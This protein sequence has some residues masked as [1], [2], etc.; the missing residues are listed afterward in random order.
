[1]QR[2]SCE[3]ALAPESLLLLRQWA[4]GKYQPLRICRLIIAGLPL[5]SKITACLS[6]QQRG[7]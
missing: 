5:S 7:R 4:E 2:P 3:E 6:A 1:M